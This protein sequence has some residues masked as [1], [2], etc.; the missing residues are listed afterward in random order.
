MTDVQP[1]MAEQAML[2]RSELHG[3]LARV[4]S[5]LV[6]VGV[7]LGTSPVTHEGSPPVELKT[8]STNIGEEDLYGSF[9]PRAMSCP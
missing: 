6:R 3:C 1:T 2:L 8:G 7:A 4:E 5:F 9:S